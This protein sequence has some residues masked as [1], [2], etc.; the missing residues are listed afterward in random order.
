[1]NND[2]SSRL[3]DFL[4]Q[5]FLA[6]L[7]DDDLITDISFNGRSVYY[8]HNDYGRARSAIVVSAQEVNDFLRQI[9]NL[10]EKQFSYSEPLLDM[11]FGRFRLNA[12]HYALGRLNDSKTPTFSLRIGSYQTRIKDDGSFMPESISKIIDILIANHQSLVIGGVTGT[13]KT[14]LQKYLLSRIKSHERVV[15][16]DN[17]QELTYNSANENIDLTCWQV[18]PHLQHASFPELIRNALRSNPDWLVIAESR[19]KE[20]IDVLNSAMTG[21]PVLTTIHAKSVDTIASRMVRM[22]LLN[23][24]ETSY[25]EASNDIREHFRY[26]LYLKKESD[27]EGRIRRFLSSFLE[28]EHESQQTFLIYQKTSDGTLFN[29]PSPYTVSLIKSC[30]QGE[31]IMEIFYRCESS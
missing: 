8:Q 1:M 31:N 3:I 13:G 5:S 30:Q 28:I 22:V 19:G 12:V 27:G 7:L 14:E 15:V 25:K 26:Y 4:H 10:G 24:Q 23:G 6:P 18:N 21:H 2:N 16:I 11:S 17:I 20:M 29:T 9:A